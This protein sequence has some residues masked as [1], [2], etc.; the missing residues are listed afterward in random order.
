MTTPITTNRPTIEEWLASEAMMT[1]MIAGFWQA[2]VSLSSPAVKAI[3]L[4]LSD[5]RDGKVTGSLST[6][7]DKNLPIREELIAWA[8]TGRYLLTRGAGDQVRL[9]REGWLFSVEKLQ[10]FSDA[11]SF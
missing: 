8:N 4:T 11:S 1:V 5:F 6:Q 2:S 9:G 3:P 10:Y 7:L